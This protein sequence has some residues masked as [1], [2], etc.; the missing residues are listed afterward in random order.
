M[1]CGYCTPGMMIAARD[2]ATR[3]PEADEARV[4]VELSGNLC[5]VARATCR[6]CQAAVQRVLEERKAAG[7]VGEP[8]LTTPIASR[9]AAVITPTV[10]PAVPL[11]V[12]T[13]PCVRPPRPAGGRCDRRSHHPRGKSFTVRII[14]GT[15]VWAYVRGH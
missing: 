14:P 4:R 13:E 15:R 7:E 12:P 9:P 10:Q 11:A 3:L 2:I 5:A 8:A 6:D 1:Q